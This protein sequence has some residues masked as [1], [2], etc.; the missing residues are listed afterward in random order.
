[1]GTD[2]KFY[3]NI[4]SLV[5]FSGL[6]FKTTQH[7]ATQMTVLWPFIESGR[8]RRRNDVQDLS[9]D[10]LYSIIIE[11]YYYSIIQYSLLNTANYR[12]RSNKL[13]EQ[14]GTRL[15]SSRDEMKNNLGGFDLWSLKGQ[16]LRAL[17]R[18]TKLDDIRSGTIPCLHYMLC[19]LH[20]TLE[21]NILSLTEI[22]WLTDPFWPTVHPGF[23]QTGEDRSKHLDLQP[24]IL[25]HN[26][27]PQPAILTLKTVSYI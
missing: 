18:K 11:Y 25:V 24:R 9:E 6:F 3:L 12:L 22:Y 16:D 1:M 21:T 23:C 10:Q 14:V 7:K 27:L 2:N 26:L 13:S 5:C 8:A 19:T 20:F 15:A 4:F 17:I